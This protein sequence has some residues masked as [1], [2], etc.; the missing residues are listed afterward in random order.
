MRRALESLIK[1]VKHV[2]KTITLDRIFTVEALCNFNYENE[3][4]I[5]QRPL[6]AI[7][8][9]ANDFDNLTLHCVSDRNGKSQN[10]QENSLAKRI[11]QAASNIFWNRWRKEYL[12]T[13]IV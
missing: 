9:D 13:V 2:L 11:A 10:C 7:S 8:D 12:P 5:N 6:M 1:S 4:I 3:C